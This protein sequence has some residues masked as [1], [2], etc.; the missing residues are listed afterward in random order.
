[1]WLAWIDTYVGPPDTIVTDASTN[2]TAA[3]FKANA[4]IIAIE[5]EEVPVEAHNSIGKLER[6]HAPLRRAFNVIAADLQGQGASNEAI[7]QMAVKAVNS[8]PYANNQQ[9]RIRL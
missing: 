7:L 6:Y 3:E 2:F 4:R 8:L 9:P 5:L 1:M